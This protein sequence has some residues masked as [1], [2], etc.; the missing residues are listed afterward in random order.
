MKSLALAIALTATLAACGGGAG[1]ASPSPTARPTPSPSPAAATR[2]EFSADLRT[3]NE[4]PPIAGAE[5][6]C[7]GSGTFVLDRSAGA[8]AAA[9]ASFAFQ[10][11][12]CPA[13]AVVTIAH[14]HRGAAGANGGIVVNSGLTADQ[15]TN[16]TGGAVSVMRS[17]ISVDAALASEIVANPA[18]FYF[19]VHSRA[20]PGGVVRAQLVRRP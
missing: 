3:T 20:N 14:I 4:V 5:A 6:T 7:T 18:G 8:S 13:S 17:N 9:T 1:Q 11:S 16:L 10:L 2:I 15:P 19:N 12:A